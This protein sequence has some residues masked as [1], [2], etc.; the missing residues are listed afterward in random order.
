[1][2]LRTSYFII[3]SLEKD[4]SPLQF[5]IAMDREM[6]IAMWTFG[7]LIHETFRNASVIKSTN[8]TTPAPLARPIQCRPVG[9]RVSGVPLY[10]YIYIYPNDIFWVNKIFFN[11][12]QK[13]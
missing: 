2:Q 3:F 13:N 7:K 9:G 11:Y 12:F 10:I 8:A 6:R 4:H 5:S 1:M